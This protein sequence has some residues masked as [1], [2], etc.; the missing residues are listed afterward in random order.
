MLKISKNSNI[1]SKIIDFILK[2]GIITINFISN[3][4]E[5]YMLSEYS[6]K[7]QLGDYIASRFTI[8][9]LDAYFFDDKVVDKRGETFTEFI[10]RTRNN[11]E[12]YYGL[13]CYQS[14]SE[15]VDLYKSEGIFDIRPFRALM[16]HKMLLMQRLKFFCDSGKW[17][18]VDWQKYMKIA[19]HMIELAKNQFFL[20][21][22][23]NSLKDFTSINRAL[24]C[25]EE[26]KQFDEDFSNMLYQELF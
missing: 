12:Y 25:I 13:D 8:E 7:T 18:S 6:I 26:L 5:Q 17:N 3:K 2:I 16:E 14:F 19:E 24:Q 11:N 23:E 10:Y 22:K 4:T 1:I 9:K 15:Y 21:L 20:C